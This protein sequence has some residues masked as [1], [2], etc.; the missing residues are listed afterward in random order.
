MVI[1]YKRNRGSGADE[2]P[3]EPA[4]DELRGKAI[5][6]ERIRTAV[7]FVGQMDKIRWTPSAMKWRYDMTSLTG[8]CIAMVF[9]FSERKHMKRTLLSLVV[10]L[11]S[12]TGCTPKTQEDTLIVGLEC[13]YSPF[14]WTTVSSQSDSSVKIDEDGAGFCD[15][16]DIVV[17]QAIA[18]GLEKT[19]IVKKIA[20]GGL[21]QAL[22]EGEIDM[23]V[24][25]MTDTEE[26]RQSVSFT[27]P[28]YASDLVMVV[29]A[30][31]S[32]ATATTLAE[33]TGKNVIAQFETFHDDLIDQI[34]SV[35]HLTPLGSASLLV[36]AVKV[37]E[38][39]AMVTEYPVA[40]S[41]TSTNSELAIV[42]FAQGQG[43]ATSFEETTVSVA[44]RKS[45]TELLS[46]IN[47]IL[48]GITETTRNQWMADAIA[49]KPE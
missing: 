6:A 23:I 29:K 17:A 35:N 24:A 33:F 16:Y 49:R 15:G 2:Y 40:L 22:N 20:W 42:Q 38:A 12:L 19:L 14:N 27:V 31:S 36:N 5:T 39:D 1:P 13:D 37:G 28:Y 48:A 32:L 25:G 11:M 10:L 46:D 43:F 9:C 18:D 8:P 26:R 4:G 45:D 34:P 44:L 7:R 21:I 41:I 47:A 3:S 30:N